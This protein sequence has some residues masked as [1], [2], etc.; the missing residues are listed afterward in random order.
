MLHQASYLKKNKGILLAGFEQ[1]KKRFSFL[2][3][4]PI[5]FFF[6]PANG[7]GIINRKEK[8]MPGKDFIRL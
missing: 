3:F 5:V 1:I 4:I 2:F 7:M 8:A 6:F